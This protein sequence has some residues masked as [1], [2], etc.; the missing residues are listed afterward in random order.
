MDAIALQAQKELDRDILSYAR[1]MQNFAPVTEESVIEFEK[2]VRRRAVTGARIR[3]RLAYLVSA[4]YLERKVEWEA[5]TE[6]AH[7]RLTAT[8]AD[9]L[10]GVI[11]PRDWK[12]KQ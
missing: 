8:G 7:Y 12:G 9:M 10:D 2:N 11:P 5:G 1:E 4:G 3:D 6:L